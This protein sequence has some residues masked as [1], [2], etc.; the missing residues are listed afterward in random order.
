MTQPGPGKI[1][2]LIGVDV[3]KLID[4]VIAK[5]GSSR[6][7]L[8]PIL[9]DIQSSLG[10]LPRPALELVSSKLNVSISEILSVASFYHQFRLQPIG[11]YLIQVCFG[12]ACYLRGSKELYEALRLTLGKSHV[13][14]E[15]ARCFGCCSLAPVIMVVNTQTGEKSIHGRLRSTDIGKITM[16][17]LKK[18]HR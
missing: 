12:T 8:I 2:E 14:I 6:D 16:Q 13:S 10:Y 9:Q 1:E 7:R 18:I 15:K 17:Y 11:E 3:L 4:S 5:Y